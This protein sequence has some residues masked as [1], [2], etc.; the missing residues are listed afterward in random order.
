MHIAFDA[1]R[2]FLNS[3][4]LGNY[5]RTL[6][7][8]L[9]DLHPENH[10]TLFTPR[11]AE[12]EFQKTISTQSTITIQEPEHFIDKKL[13]S[14]WRSYG[15]TPILTDKQVDV[16]HG[17]SNELP[18]NITQFKGKKIVTIHDLIFL[19]YPELYPF[20]DRKIYNKKFRNACD[21]ADA[22]IAI[23]K[24]TKRD[25]EKY[26]F[27]PESKIKVMYQSCDELY[28]QELSQAYKQQIIE[29]YKLP[30]TYLLYVGTI[31]E[32][33]N[34]LTLV[35]ALKNTKDIPLVVVGNKK[36]YFNKVMDYLTANKLQDRVYFLETVSNAE[37]PAIYSQAKIFIFPSFFEGFGIPII[38]ALTSK[39][40]VIT[41][42]GGCFPEAGGPDSI[43]ID[44]NNEKELAEKINFL[45]NSESTCKHMA[46]KGFQYAQLFHPTKCVEQLLKIYKE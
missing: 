4:G 24:E 20:I 21:N 39:V 22:I 45:L 1:K 27:I 13:R 9:N 7:K 18:F 29:K 16:Y 28:Y 33:K 11:V 31:E 3:S 35:K 40:P 43:Y 41:T 30:A 10:Y 42:A 17:L 38:E 32:R 5:A 25:I 6:I 2:A 19:R 26:Y 46:E 36:N 14:R 15:I 37:L 8:S 44:P 23:S 34:L 12:N